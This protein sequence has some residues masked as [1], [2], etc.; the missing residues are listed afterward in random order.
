MTTATSAY[1]NQPPKPCPAA[2]SGDRVGTGFGP[3]TISRVFWWRPSSGVP[4]WR[5]DVALDDGQ[6]ANCGTVSPC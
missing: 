6:I 5:Y 3:G 1:L 2:L 4:H